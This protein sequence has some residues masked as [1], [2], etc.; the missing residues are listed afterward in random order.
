MDFTAIFIFLFLISLCLLPS[1]VLKKTTYFENKK[2]FLRKLSHFFISFVFI[3]TTFFLTNLEIYFFALFLLLAVLI[4]KNLKL[5]SSIFKTKRKTFGIIFFPVSLTIST[6]VFLPQSQNAFIFGM[7]IL[8]ISDSLAAVLGKNLGKKEII[9]N[10]T[11]VGSFAFFISTFLITIFF[12]PNLSFILILKSL[13][14]AFFVTVVEV[15]LKY[16]LDN[17]FIPLFS[18]LLFVLLI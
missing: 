8:A 14:I 1:E 5:F 11:Y 18:G 6:F 2:E 13:F 9:K 3:L 16:G 4:A 10:K 17:I 7:A 15:V 12:L